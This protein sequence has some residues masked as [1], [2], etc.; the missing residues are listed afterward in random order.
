MFKYDTDGSVDRFKS[1]L[2]S[3]GFTQ[4][5]GIGY[6][7]TFASVAKLKTIRFFFL[8]LAINL[9]WPLHQL[10]VKNAFLNGDLE[11]E[12]YMVIPSG[13]EMRETLPTS[14]S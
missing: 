2:I 9:D 11:E 7:D 10:D 3:E 8:S 12:V 5:Y 14:T 1:R 4:S 6:L 13:I